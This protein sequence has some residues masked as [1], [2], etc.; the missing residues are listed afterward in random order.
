M[1]SHLKYSSLSNVWLYFICS[2]KVHLN[3]GRT[4]RVH[5]K[6]TALGCVCH[7]HPRAHHT[8]SC[9]CL[10]GRTSPVPIPLLLAAPIK[11]KPESVPTASYHNCRKKTGSGPSPFSFIPSL[12]LNLF[13]SLFTSSN[14][15]EFSRRPLFQ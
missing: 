2:L 4:T 3:F 15:L 13:Q 11:K 1:S 14:H 8:L 12:C 9:V 10:S 5:S 7:P 6:G